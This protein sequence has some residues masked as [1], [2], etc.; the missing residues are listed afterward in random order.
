M[1]ALKDRALANVGEQ[2]AG[3]KG[4]EIRDLAVGCPDPF[5]VGAGTD[6]DR[7]VWGVQA[8]DLG[9]LAAHHVL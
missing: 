7:I 4:T 3:H 1:S 5:P 9:P 6:H 8:E 2:F